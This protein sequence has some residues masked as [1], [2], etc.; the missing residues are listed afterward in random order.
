MPGQHYGKY[1]SEVIEELRRK[2]IDPEKATYLEYRRAYST[3]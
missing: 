2:G 3:V 1:K